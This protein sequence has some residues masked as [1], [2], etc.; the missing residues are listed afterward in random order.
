MRQVASIVTDS[1]EKRSWFIQA[2]PRASILE[3][4]PH[5]RTAASHKGAVIPPPTDLEAW[6]DQD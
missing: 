3:T 2:L 6:Q 4:R 5:D 1:C